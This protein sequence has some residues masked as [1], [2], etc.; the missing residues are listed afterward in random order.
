MCREEAQRLG[1][2]TSTIQKVHR[3]R[4]GF[5]EAWGGAASGVERKYA[6]PEAKRRRGPQGGGPRQKLPKC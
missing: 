3:G 2:Q 5:E 4:Q 6:T 1:P